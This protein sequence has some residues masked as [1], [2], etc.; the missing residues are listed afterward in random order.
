MVIEGEEGE[1]EEGQPKP[2]I[3]PNGKPTIQLDDFINE[4]VN[5]SLNEDTYEN[6]LIH[7]FSLFDRDKYIS[8]AN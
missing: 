2:K 1:E 6:C 4:I 7:A 5:A 8:I 3:F